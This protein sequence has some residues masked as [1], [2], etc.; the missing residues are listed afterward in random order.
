MRQA[1]GRHFDNK[2]EW[3]LVV[4]KLSF[5]LQTDII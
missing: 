4:F 2:Y 1:G 3:V 5:R